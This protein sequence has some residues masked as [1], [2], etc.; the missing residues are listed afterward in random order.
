MEKKTFKFNFN[1]ELPQKLRDAV[2]DKINISLDKENSLPNNGPTYFSWDRMCAIMDRL[3]DTI[4][5]V[6]GMELGKCRSSRSAFDFYEFINCLYVIIDCIKTMDT[7]FDTKKEEIYKIEN[8]QDC[9][10]NVM[11]ANGTDK[12]FFDYIRSLSTVHPTNTT[13]NGSHKHPYMKNDAIHCCP[14]VLWMNSP[15]SP[16]YNDGRDLSVRIYKAK[17]DEK[18]IDLP[19]WIGQFEK[20]ANKWINL[21]P[22]TIEQIHNYNESIYEE[23]R[24]EPIKKFGEYKNTIECLAV[25]KR[26]YEKRFGDESEY[27]FDYFINIFRYYLTDESNRNKLEKYRNA[28]EY[29]LP[30]L[31]NSLQTMDKKG[32][33]NTGINYPEDEEDID[34]FSL[35]EYCYEFEGAFKGYTYVL[36]KLTYLEPYAKYGWWDKEY[37]RKLLEEIKPIIN[38]YVHFT[39]EESDYETIILVNLALYF[40]ALETKCLLN[41]NIPNE[42]KFRLRV[43]DDNE[44]KSLFKKERK[45][46]AKMPDKIKIHIVDCSGNVLEE[47]EIKFEKEKA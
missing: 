26:E 9:F 35:L 3:E 20:Y 39:N 31:I 12:Q 15:A 7:M 47:Q 27:V 38:K 10:G 17:K 6:N 25:L 32:F 43:L 46:K 40:D 22:H 36:S 30:F 2:N 28:I 44:Y 23:L 37:A 8:T 16:F 18:F 24:K 34:L 11:E 4:E 41:Q 13:G 33:M 14:F 1:T 42:E 5:Y 21:I 19:L 45:K 29:S